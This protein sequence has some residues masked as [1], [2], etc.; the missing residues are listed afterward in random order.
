MNKVFPI[1]AENANEMCQ[2][3][4]WMDSREAAIVFKRIDDEIKWSVDRNIKEG[5]IYYG[6]HETC[7]FV[8]LSDTAIESLK[9]LG[10]TVTETKVDTSRNISN[11]KGTIVRVSWGVKKQ[12]EQPKNQSDE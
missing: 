1:S 4:S 10:Y 11:I 9:R 3:M 2:S 12:N 7:V 6:P 5:R 8:D